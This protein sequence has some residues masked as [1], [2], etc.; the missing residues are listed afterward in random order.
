MKRSIEDKHVAKIKQMLTQN[1]KVNSIRDF[2]KLKY[3]VFVSSA[4]IQSIK[5]MNAYVTV[6]PELN[7]TIRKIHSSRLHKDEAEVIGDVKWALANGYSDDEI[8]KSYEVSDSKL[9]HIKYGYMPYYS[10][11]TQYNSAIEKKFAKR[12][13]ANIDRRMVVAIKKEF[14]EKN[15]DVSLNEIAEKHKIESA[16]VS[17]ILN[18]KYYKEFGRSFNTRIIG[19]KK[20]KEAIKKEKETRR[21]E[22][23]I[24]KVKQLNQALLQK[25][26]Q[27]EEKLKESNDYLKTLKNAS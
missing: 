19:I 9:K 24:E 22:A 4:Q 26:N 12:K 13:K 6:N 8:M 16:T 5:I 10:I 23:K 27:I 21:I 11:S 25:K 17:T 1:Y 15:G 18:F 20:R 14:V 3:G 2:M 7:D